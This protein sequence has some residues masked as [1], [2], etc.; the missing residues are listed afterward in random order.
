[1]PHLASKK[2]KYDIDYRAF[3]DGAGMYLMEDI[4]NHHTIRVEHIVAMMIDS[5]DKD[6][7]SLYGRFSLETHEFLGVYSLR[8]NSGHIGPD[9]VAE[10]LFLPMDPNLVWRAGAFGNATD[11][12]AWWHI[13]RIGI[14]PGGPRNTR[15]WTMMSI[16]CFSGEKNVLGFRNARRR[17]YTS[18][19]LLLRSCTRTT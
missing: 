18:F 19:T 17:R 3:V 16:V 10:A 7:F 1:M 8:V 15:G 6:R 13:Q 4:W 2:G 9:W 12:E 11:I 5:R 14:T